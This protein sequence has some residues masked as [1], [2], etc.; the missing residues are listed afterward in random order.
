MLTLCAFAAEV[1]EDWYDQIPRAV[2][3]DVLDKDCP[4]IIDDAIAGL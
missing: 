3:L 2:V 1:P 4:I